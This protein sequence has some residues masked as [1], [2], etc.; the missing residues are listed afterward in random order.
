MRR[1]EITYFSLTGG[2]DWGEREECPRQC[3]ARPDHA[4]PERLRRGVRFHKT[5]PSALDFFVLLCYDMDIYNRKRGSS[6]GFR[7]LF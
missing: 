1:I 5:L 3:P 6:A 7:G 4:S 2:A